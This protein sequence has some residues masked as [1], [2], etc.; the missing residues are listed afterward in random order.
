MN[1]HVCD[2]LLGL[3]HRFVIWFI[4]FRFARKQT[5]FWGVSC[6][7]LFCSGSLGLQEV[8]AFNSTPFL[9]LE[10]AWKCLQERE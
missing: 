9:F 4:V 2:G 5:T 1:A 8:S 3:S 10:N 6:L 7:C